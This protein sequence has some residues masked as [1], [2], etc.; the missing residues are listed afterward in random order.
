MQARLAG[1]FPE[2]TSDIFE[3]LHHL[4]PAHQAEPER[5]AATLSAFWERAENRQ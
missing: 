2:F 4:N 1:L 5:A 3:G